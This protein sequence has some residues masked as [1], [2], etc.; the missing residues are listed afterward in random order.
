MIA[1]PMKVWQEQGWSGVIVAVES[2]GRD[3]QNHRKGLLKVFSKLQNIGNA[4]NIVANKPHEADAF[5]EIFWVLLASN[6]E[7]SCG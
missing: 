6:H 4:S 5:V 2:T 7:I 1:S 3:G